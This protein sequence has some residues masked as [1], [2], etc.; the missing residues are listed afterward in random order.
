MAYALKSN[1]ELLEKEKFTDEDLRKRAGKAMWQCEY[2]FDPK[3]ADKKAN[4][5]DFDR[6]GVIFQIFG[7]ESMLK[8]NDFLAAV[9]SEKVN[10]IFS[11]EKIRYRMRKYYL[12]EDFLEMVDL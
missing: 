1:P 12:D 9:K 11:D 4:Y 3:A 6:N 2:E 7:F 10:W 5:N 8:K